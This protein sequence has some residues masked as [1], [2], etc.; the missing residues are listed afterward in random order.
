MLVRGGLFIE[1]GRWYAQGDCNNNN[2]PLFA[3]K[4]YITCVRN[5]HQTTTSEV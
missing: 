1:V 5:F 2:T 4:V 3:D